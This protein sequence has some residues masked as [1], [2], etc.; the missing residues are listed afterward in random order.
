MAV[1]WSRRNALQRIWIFHLWPSVWASACQVPVGAGCG[2]HDE[3]SQHL[4]KHEKK[5]RWIND[6]RCSLG[7]KKTKHREKNQ[8]LWNFR[9]FPKLQSFRVKWGGSEVSCGI[10]FFFTSLRIKPLMMSATS[11]GG[12]NFSDSITERGVFLQTQR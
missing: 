3:N 2:C 5:W 12:Q 11:W 6:S 9:A 4:K 10:F 1:C 8:R 7:K